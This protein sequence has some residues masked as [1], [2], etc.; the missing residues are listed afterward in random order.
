MAAMRLPQHLAEKVVKHVN[1]KSWWHV[2]PVDPDA[3]STRGQFL[4]SSFA[5]AEFYG[6]PVDE[7]QS[8]CVANPLVGDEQVIS[9]VLGVLP[10]HERMSLKQISAHDARWRNAALKKGFDSVL[11]MAPAGFARFK[12]TGKLPRN[13]ELNVLRIVDAGK[14]LL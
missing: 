7:P 12:T 1:R 6:R 14:S 9:R 5:A 10:Q 4:A 3:F 8:V 2:P 13:L 11:L